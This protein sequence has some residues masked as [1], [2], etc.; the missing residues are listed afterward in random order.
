M[1]TKFYQFTILKR[2]PQLVA[3]ITDRDW[4]NFSLAFDSNSKVRQNKIKLAKTLKVNEQNIFSVRQD[5]GSKIIIIKSAKV[6]SEKIV[7]DGMITKVKNLILMIKTADCFPVLMFDPQKQLIG[8]FHVG[9][10]G[11]IQ[12]IF[13]SGLLQMINQFQCQAKN[14]LVAIGPGIRQCCC[15]HKNLLQ[16]KL[17]EWQSYINQEKNHWQSLDILSFI[18]DQLILAGVTKKNIEAMTVCTSCNNNF[19]SHWRSLKKNEPEGRFATLI[20]LIN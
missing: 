16:A 9:W 15:Q 7:G 20:G 6:K 17:P 19:F 14:I 1:A 13:I 18:K 3:G 4:G 8:A 5:H 2:Y 12:K 11:A 10:R